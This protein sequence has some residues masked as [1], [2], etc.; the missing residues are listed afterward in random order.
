MTGRNDIRRNDRNPTPFLFPGLT[1]R[2][3]GSYGIGDIPLSRSERMDTGRLGV[4]SGPS[5]ELSLGVLSVGWG[6]TRK[7]VTLGLGGDHR[8]TKGPLSEYLRW[9]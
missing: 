5:R 4:R 1:I 9:F 6:S 2:P 3:W 8:D 7:S